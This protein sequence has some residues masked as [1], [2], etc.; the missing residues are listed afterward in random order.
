MDQYQ[1]ALQIWQP[2]KAQFELAERALDAVHVTG[3]NC[4]LIGWQ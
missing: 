3:E 1:Q 2:T 4:C